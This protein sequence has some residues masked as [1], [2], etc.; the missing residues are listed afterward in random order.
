M[1]KKLIDTGSNTDKHEEQLTELSSKLSNYEYLL[2][3]LITK[4]T[5]IQPLSL[6]NTKL[7]DISFKTYNNEEQLTDISSKLSTY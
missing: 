2:K 7:T 4:D 6:K 3:K 5:Q 1:L